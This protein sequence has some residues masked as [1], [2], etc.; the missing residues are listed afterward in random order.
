M[1]GKMEYINSKICCCCKPYAEN[2]FKRYL[3]SK[4]PIVQKNHSHRLSLDIK[5]ML[6]GENEDV[7]VNM[8][9]YI[10]IRHFD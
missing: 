10:L 9:D 8:K 5:T 4:Y 6:Y 7:F 3:R 1:T 2:I